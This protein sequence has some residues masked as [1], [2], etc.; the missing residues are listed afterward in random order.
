MVF[1]ST[2]DELQIAALKLNEIAS[3]YNMSISAEKTKVMAFQGTNHKRCKIVIDNKSIEQVNNF[4]YLGF[5]V[6]YCQKNDI[7]MKLNRFYNMCGTIRRTLKNKTL[8]STQL[9]FYKTMAVPTLTYACENWT[10][11]RSDKRKIETAEMKFL[12]SV[13]GYRLLDKKPSKEIREELNMDNLIDRIQNLKLNWLHHI[14]RMS[15]NRLPRVLLNYHPKGKRNV[16]RPIL[17]WSDSI[18]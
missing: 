5:N 4:N 2:E 14:E 11:N 10:I 8:K 16:G 12:R 6:S 1:S 7:N 15:S 3:R 13:A 18:S 17:R 9:K